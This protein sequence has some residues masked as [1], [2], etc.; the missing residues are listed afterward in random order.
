MSWFK[1]EKKENEDLS[2]ELTA[3]REQ[4]A[5][6]EAAKPQ[7]DE[8]VQELRTHLKENHMGDRLRLSF[9]ESRRRPTNG[10]G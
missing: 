4:L 3:A 5:R 6:A 1:R 8:L 2:H 7:V 9:Q 10:V